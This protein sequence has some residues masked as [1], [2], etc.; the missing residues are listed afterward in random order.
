[1]TMDPEWSHLVADYTGS[2]YFSFLE[3]ELKEH[4]E[5]VLTQALDAAGEIS[6]DFPEQAGAA[7]FERALTERVAQPELPAD[8]QRRAPE[9][10]SGFFEYLAASGR[11]PQALAWAEWIPELET[12]YAARLREDGSVRGRTVRKT[13]AD[14]GRNDPCPCGSGLKFKKCCIDVLG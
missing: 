2:E 14:V 3:D 4:A 11:Y 8:I 7:L 10:L 1:M 5:A 13:L 6:P 9:L 12:S